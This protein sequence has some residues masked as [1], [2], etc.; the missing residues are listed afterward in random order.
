MSQLPV[1][2][3]QSRLLGRGQ[4]PVCAWQFPPAFQGT[5]L[6]LL[7]LPRWLSCVTLPRCAASLA[8][9]RGEESGGRSLGEHRAL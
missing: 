9:C 8:P 4:H 2:L 1:P 6:L 7:A 5:S 3:Q